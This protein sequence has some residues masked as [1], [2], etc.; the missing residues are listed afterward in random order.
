MAATQTATNYYFG[1]KLIKA[2]NGYLGT[3]RLGSI[4]KYYP[5]GQEK[6]SATQNGTVKFTGYLRDS[7]TGLDYAMNRYHN[8]GTGRFLTPDNSGMAIVPTTPSSWNRYA[9]AAGD[10]VRYKDPSGLYICDECD[11]AACAIANPFAP[12]PEDPSCEDPAEPQQPSQPIESCQQHVADILP[13]DPGE[14]AAIQR[15]L[16]ENGYTFLLGQGHTTYDT[17][18]NPNGK[19]DRGEV[20]L[21]DV[22]IFSVLFNRVR[23]SQSP[24]TFALFKS[25][26]LLAAVQQTDKD[27]SRQAGIDI[28]NQALASTRADTWQ[29]ADLTDA[30]FALEQVEAGAGSNDVY[31][32][33]AVINPDGSLR[34]FNPKRDVR[35]GLTDFVRGIRWR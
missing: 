15:V 31:Y 4:G 35:I 22:Y 1:G 19:L 34:K 29:C 12:G 21:T 13:T 26:T 9:Y 24:K 11:P 28:Y 30:I 2:T 17:K 32:W 14:I 23:L 25:P 10:P 27:G 20:D 18:G 3:D 33:F 5:Y 7:E 8:P 16:N 6:P